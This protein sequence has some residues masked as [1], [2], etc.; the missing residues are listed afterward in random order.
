MLSTKRPSLVPSR[1]SPSSS[2]SLTQ[3]PQQPFLAAVIALFFYCFFLSLSGS[4]VVSLGYID[5]VQHHP[6][7]I[8]DRSA[9]GHRL[10]GL[11][12]LPREWVGGGRSGGCL[13]Y[14]SPGPGD[15]S[16]LS[17]LLTLHAEV[18]L[19]PLRP[20]QQQLSTLTGGTRRR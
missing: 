13:S 2:G 19:S 8:F 18:S 1:P 10:T 9:S 17:Q 5:C 20:L 3:G 11:L 12:T 15:E 6:F 7:S 16:S 4:Y 14:G